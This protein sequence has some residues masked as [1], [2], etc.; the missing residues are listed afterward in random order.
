M[1]CAEGT[2]G[3]IVDYCIDQTKVDEVML[4][5]KVIYITH[6][7]A[8]HNLGLPRFLEERDKLLN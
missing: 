7:H 3:Q 2:Y 6:L 1:D 8:D 5:T 4:K